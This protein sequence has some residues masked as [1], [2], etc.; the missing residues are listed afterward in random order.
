MNEQPQPPTEAAF[1]TSIREWGVVRGTSGVVGGVV[2]G[3]GHKIGL[4]RV[5]A[6]LLTVVA[7]ILLPG[8]VMVAYAAGWALLPDA[9]GNI[10]I[11]DFGRGITNVGALIG[12]A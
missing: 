1:F 9:R 11:Q 5:P 2:E 6:R 7:W 3:V 10:I 12:I 4:A 8:V